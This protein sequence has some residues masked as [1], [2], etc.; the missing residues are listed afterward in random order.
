MIN[1]I[2]G[3]ISGL[4]FVKIISISREYIYRKRTKE[5][6]KVCHSKEDLD[7]AIEDI[8]N[9]IQ[10]NIKNGNKASKD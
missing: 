10:E 9:D 6:V 8:L 2:I 5:Y 3:L 1:Y 7:K 4:C